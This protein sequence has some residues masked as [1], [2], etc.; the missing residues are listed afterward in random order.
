MLFRAFRFAPFL[1]LLA[2][3]P[4]VAAASASLTGQVRDEQGHSVAKARVTLFNQV[5]GHR[6][7]ALT[8][9][10]GSFAFPNVPFN[11]YHL[12]A[13][14]P[15]FNLWHQ[16]VKLRSTLPAHLNVMLASLGATVAVTEQLGLVEAHPSA[17]LDIDKSAIELA[18]AAVQSRAMESILLATPGFTQN[19]NGRFHFRGSHGQVMF[20]V[21][22][23][24][25]T[26][27]INTTFSNSLDPS[28]VEGMEIITGGIAAEYG[29]KPVAV[30]NMTTQ[31]GLGTS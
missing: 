5:T 31:S 6:Q 15:G 17:H 28:Q 16:D 13:T 21:D 2:A 9:A 26:D 30:V 24:P 23:I 27:Q 7:T 11:D 14:A 19:E 25:V 22:G 10:K 18:P 4:A 12:E 3:A 8:D 29:G 20:V 1:C